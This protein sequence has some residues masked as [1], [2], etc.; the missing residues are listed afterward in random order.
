MEAGLMRKQGS[1]TR[2]EKTYAAKEN[3][4]TTSCTWSS[5]FPSGLLPEDKVGGT[6]VCTMWICMRTKF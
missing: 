1:S 6:A 3:S 2:M 5:C 4:T